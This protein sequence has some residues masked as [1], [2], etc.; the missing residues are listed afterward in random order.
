[1]HLSDSLLDMWWPE[2]NFFGFIFRIWMLTNFCQNH[3]LQL[4][5]WHYA[6]HSYHQTILAQLIQKSQTFPIPGDRRCVVAIDCKMMLSCFPRIF[7]S[8]SSNFVGF[9]CLVMGVEWY[10]PPYFFIGNVGLKRFQFYIS[11]LI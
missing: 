11:I 7:V 8:P 3:N 6:I 1:M 10:V 9:M 4:C 5:F 2:T